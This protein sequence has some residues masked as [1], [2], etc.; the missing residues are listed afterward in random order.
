MTGIF[1]S[2][3]RE[4]SSGWA[5]RLSRDLRANFGDD[6]VFEDIADIEPGID[7]AEAIEKKLDSVNVLLAVIGPRWLA[8][9]DKRTARRRLD[10]PDDLV[11]KEIATALRRGI[12][13]VPVLVGGASL[14]SPEELPD[15][16]RGLLRRNACELSDTRWDYDVRQLT[17][18]LKSVRSGRFGTALADA[19]WS[20]F[21]GARRGYTLASI[22]VIAVFALFGT[23]D[24]RF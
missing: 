20:S 8:A 9:A 16:L 12:R 15:D 23:L 6:E 24:E 22:A 2:Y 21:K 3:R 4:D 7:F 17:L 14:P 5:G 1:I 18:R 10:D 11:R 19:L 13:V